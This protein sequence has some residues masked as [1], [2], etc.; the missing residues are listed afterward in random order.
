MD[1]DEA[2]TLLAKSARLGEL[3]EKAAKLARSILAEL[4]CLTLAIDQ[5]GALLFTGVCQ[6]DDF[7]NTSHSHRKGLMQKSSYK[8]AS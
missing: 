4:G 7:L 1:E 5:A 8:A 6:L 2:V 3:S